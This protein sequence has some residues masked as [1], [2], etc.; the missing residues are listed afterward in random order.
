MSG[1]DERQETGQGQTQQALN[2]AWPVGCQ[3]GGLGVLGLLM[4]STRNPGMR[5][6]FVQIKI[7][8]ITLL[9]KYKF[10]VC[11]KTVLP[12]IIDKQNLTKTILGGVWLRIENRFT[13]AKRKGKRNQNSR[14]EFSPIDKI[15]SVLAQGTNRRTDGQTKNYSS[16]MASLVLTD[17]SQLTADGF[18][19]LPDQ[20]MYAYAEPYDMQK[21]CVQQLSL[22]TERVKTTWVM[23]VVK[24]EGEKWQR[25]EY[26]DLNK[27]K[28]GSLVISSSNLLSGNIKGSAVHPTTVWKVEGYGSKPRTLR[29][30]RLMPLEV[31]GSK[32]GICC[33]GNVGGFNMDMSKDRTYNNVCVFLVW[34]GNVTEAMA[35]PRLTIRSVYTLKY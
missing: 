1:A 28:V 29:Q 9:S 10:S 11:E 6:A 22:L 18:E 26:S 12:P 3:H 24:E 32:K 30:I 13:I 4:R 14:V 15:I 20:I 27:S 21:T 19:K 34:S 25:V 2:R 16:P 17:S 31:P 23:R 8:L 7:G 5:F 33:H 35:A